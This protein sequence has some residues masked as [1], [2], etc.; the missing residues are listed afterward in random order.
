MSDKDVDD[1]GDDGDD[2]DD[3]DGEVD[4]NDNDEEEALFPL[5]PNKNYV[6]TFNIYN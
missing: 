2:D 4:D 1:G 5:D 3:D 6:A